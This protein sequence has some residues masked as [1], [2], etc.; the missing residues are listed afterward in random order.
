VQIA[1]NVLVRAIRH[2]ERDDLVGRNVAALVD[3]PKGQQVGRPSK[4]LTL[5][6]A[7]EL[8]AAAKGTALEAYIIV[9]LLSLGAD[10]GGAGSALGPRH[11][12]GG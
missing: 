9:S 6:Q 1:H 3:A 2:P 11:G 7:V 5:E 8:M 10:R 12:V 4:S